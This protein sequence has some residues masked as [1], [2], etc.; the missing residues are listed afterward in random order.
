M[1][2]RE[3]LLELE[4]AGWDALKNGTGRRHYADLLTEDAV[5]LLPGVGLL[6]H[7]KALDGMDGQPWSWFQLRNPQVLR[8][9]DDAALWTRHLWIRLRSPCL[10][11][12]EPE[13]R[14][15]D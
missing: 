2:L 7:D 15:H 11:P 8:L 4:T 13:D 12:D 1:E 10:Q 6:S 9:G 5:M 3:E 14:T